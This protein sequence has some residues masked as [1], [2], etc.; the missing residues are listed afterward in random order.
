MKHTIRINFEFPKNHHPYLKM[1]CAQKGL[2]IKD[3]ASQLLIQ[4]IEEYEEDL[5]GKKARRRLDEL[6]ANENISF[7]D[8]C[9][10]AGW[11]D[12]QEA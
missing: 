1:L 5:L 10:L 6:D 7:D 11:D 3:F 4:A 9:K 2:S 12:D 8:A